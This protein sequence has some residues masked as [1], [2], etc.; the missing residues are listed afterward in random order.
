MDEASSAIE[1][2]FCVQIPRSRVVVLC[3]IPIH[4]T[5]DHHGLSY[6]VMSGRC[7]NS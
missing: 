5:D 6:H 2:Q 3:T 1:R 4:L 7:L